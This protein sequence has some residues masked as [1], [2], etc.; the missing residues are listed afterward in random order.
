MAEHFENDV[1][2]LVCYWL[3]KSGS[4]NQKINKSEKRLADLVRDESGVQFAIAFIDRVIRPEDN[5]IAAANMRQL[6]LNIPAFLPWHQRVAMKV[7]AKF[8][9]PLPWLVMPITKRVLRALVG[10]LVV[11]ARERKFNSAM[12]RMRS[13]G[14]SVNVNLLG[15]AVLG[16]NEAMKRRD[17]I[18]ALLQNKEVDYVSVKVSAIAAQLSMWGFDQ[19]VERVIERLLPIYRIADRE[20][21]FVNLDMEEYR[22]LDL[23]IA[24]FTKILDRFPSLKAGIVL[25]AYLPD[26][27]RSMQ[28]LQQWAATRRSNGGAAIKVRVVKGANLQMEKVD[29]TIHGWPLAT[30]DSK[31]LSD[32]NYKRVL[33]WALTPKRVNNIHIGIAG[34][35][36]FDIAHSW[37]LAKQRGVEQFVEFEMLLGMASSQAEAIR[38]DVG[39][40]L[41]YVPV[42]HPKDFDAAIAYLVRRLEENSSQENFMSAVFDIDK[43]QQLFERET[44]RYLTSVALMNQEIAPTHRVQDRRTAPSA[45]QGAFTNTPDTD[46]SVGANRQWAKQIAARITNSTVGI[47]NFEI[48]DFEKLEDAIKETQAAGIRWGQRAPDERAEIL[49]AAGHKLNQMRAELIEVMASECG[50]VIGEGD[51]EVSEAVDFANYYADQ[52]SKLDQIQGAKFS[53]D[54][55]T[56][57]APPWN[58]PVA[59]VAGSTLAALAAG[60]GVIVKPAPQA[61]RS[62]T[63]MVQALW[64]GGVPRDVLQLLNVP[65]GE[66]GRALISHPLVDNVILTGSWETAA[67]FKSWRPELSLSAETSGKNAIVVTEDADLD[68]AAGD[69]ARSAFGHAGQKC[70]AASIAI[71]V[72]SVGNSPRFKRQLID[73][74]Q[75]MKVGHAID[76]E[77]V[78][79]PVIETPTGKLKWALSELEPGESW[80]MQP[81][82]IDERLYRPGIRAGVKKGARSHLEEFFGPMLA[83]V[84]VETLAEALEVQNATEYGLTAGLHS[85]NQDEIEYWLENVQAGNLY[86]NRGITGAIVQRQ[87]FGGWKRSSVGAGFKAGGPNYVQ[88][89]GTWHKE[90]IEQIPS[91]L[92][93][94]IETLLSDAGSTLNAEEISKLRTSFALDALS[95]SE[96]F[97]IAKDVSNLGVEINALRHVPRDNVTIRASHDADDFDVARLIG[98]ALLAN[99]PVKLSSANDRHRVFA[100]FVNEFMVQD[101][102]EFLDQIESSNPGRIRLIGGEEH[103]IILSAVGTHPDWFVNAK[104][105]TYSG[106]IELL[107]FLKEQAVC[108]TNHRFGNR[109]GYQISLS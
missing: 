70:S 93:P 90:P 46:P 75:T 53:P 104:P 100:P 97:G 109:P 12:R 38:A 9:T 28:Y 43:N 25:Q 54:S 8:S 33:D 92:A 95:W 76:L 39:R 29:A 51:V 85:L 6:A 26:A 60:N 2:N 91:P 86:V 37:L 49:R 42:V 105:V 55:L 21:K 71:L 99:S 52:A 15:E 101:T 23:T 36:L 48:G 62:A 1:I 74:A 24:V 65:E 66:L 17:G 18:I 3:E 78:I 5:R 44:A 96:E 47:A 14:I 98:A 77:A 57:I 4:G 20:N 41:M 13:N 68:L 50:K 22:D 106:R 19:T 87:P 84:C 7:G 88:Q 58:F 61:V 73:A 69:I 89:F 83:I 10:H 31:A 80:W 67:L 11:D 79:G 82:A 16:E 81:E 94:K 107:T 59:I 34:H 45:H 102:D 103:S 56:V 32:A 30:F 64:D 35:N 72:G 63:A 27:L 40:L 108:I